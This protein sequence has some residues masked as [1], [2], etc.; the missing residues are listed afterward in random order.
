MALVTCY[1]ESVHIVQQ[2]DK[3]EYSYS[4]YSSPIWHPTSRLLLLRRWHHPIICR[5]LLLIIIWEEGRG[6]RGCIYH[7]CCGRRKT[8]RNNK[9][10]DKSF[11]QQK[12]NIL[13][14]RM[15]IKIQIIHQN[16]V[17]SACQKHAPLPEAKQTHCV[18]LFTKY[19]L[20]IT[21]M[22]KHKD[23]TSVWVRLSTYRQIRLLILAQHALF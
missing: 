6:V 13:E 5:S 9:A 14:L 8:K 10:K 20:L 2:V 22:M 19:K 3:T 17:G 12:Q 23:P 11:K 7:H 15:H 21:F 4:Q 16:I 18:T 1:S